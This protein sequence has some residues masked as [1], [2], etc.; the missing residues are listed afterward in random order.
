MNKKIPWRES[1]F[2]N[3]STKEFEEFFLIKKRTVENYR[4][5]GIP[6]EKYKILIYILKLKNEIKEREHN[7][8]LQS[9][10]KNRI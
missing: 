5:R 2:K 7:D 3:W 9:K 10:N 1:E 4:Y 8:M 6:E